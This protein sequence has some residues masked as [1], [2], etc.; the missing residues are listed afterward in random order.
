[1]KAEDFN[2]AISIVTTNNRIKISFNTPV[3]DSYSNVYQI[4]IHE[5]NASVI[6]KLV[7]AGFSLSM[8]EKGLIVDKY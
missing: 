1:M 2:E 5:S 6:N 3:N 8:C 4:L 7:S